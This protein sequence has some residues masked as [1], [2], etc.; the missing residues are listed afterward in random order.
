MIT[1]ETAA[2]IAT[3]HDDVAGAM[4]LLERVKEIAKEF[5]DSGARDKLGRVPRCLKIEINEHAV[6][7][8]TYFV[9]CTMAEQML[10]TLIGLYE[11]EM[12]RLSAKVRAELLG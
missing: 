2:D 12:E 6:H 10:Q 5:E 7:V 11:D 8:P 9:S 1:R 4:I 3:L